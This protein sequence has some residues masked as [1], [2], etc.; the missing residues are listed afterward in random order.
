MP[1]PT[2]P[3]ATGPEGAACPVLPTCKECF[4]IDYCRVNILKG[5]VHRAVPLRLQRRLQVQCFSIQAPKEPWVASEVFWGSPQGHSP[6]TRKV[7]LPVFSMEGS[8]KDLGKKWGAP[9]ILIMSQG[10]RRGSERES[11]FSIVT[12]LDS[13]Q[14]PACLLNA[15]LLSPPW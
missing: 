1:C 10:Q 12:Q 14:A 9:S 8:K 13:G 7:P 5:K 3:L 6:S 2:R 4:I 11:K 15:L